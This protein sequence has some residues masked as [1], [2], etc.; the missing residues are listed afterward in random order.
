MHF[1]TIFCSSWEHAAH[2]ATT[3]QVAWLCDWN[4]D[5]DTLVNV[6]S[7]YVS[8]FL[9]WRGYLKARDRNGH[10]LYTTYFP[11]LTIETLAVWDTDCTRIYSIP[12]IVPSGIFRRM[13]VQILLKL[14][15]RNSRESDRC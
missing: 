1:N 7:Y 4:A 3:P 10:S 15:K 6:L 5:R 11:L 14:S 2:I 8:F 12:I 13:R 9:V